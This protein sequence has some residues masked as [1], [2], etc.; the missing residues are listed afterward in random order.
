MSDGKSRDLERRGRSSRAA[1]GPRQDAGQHLAHHPRLAELGEAGADEAG[2]EHDDD[3][4]DEEGRDGGVDGTLLGRDHV[5]GG[6]RHPAAGGRQ[7]LEHEIELTPGGDAGQR[8]GAAVAAGDLVPVSR[9]PGGRRAGR[10]LLLRRRFRRSTRLRSRR[11][12]IV[13]PEALR[14]GGQLIIAGD[15]R[16][17]RPASGDPGAGGSR[18]NSRPERG[19]ADRSGECPAGV[20]DVGPIRWGGRRSSTLPVSREPLKRSLPPAP[21]CGSAKVTNWPD[22]T[23]LNCCPRQLEDPAARRSRRR[24]GPCAAPRTPARRRGNRPPAVTATKRP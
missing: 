5:L 8:L 10:G 12:Q 14:P 22:W 7:R 20:P 15:A 11:A 23:T 18:L 1:S 2:E 16:W 13:P 9:P 6:E 4:R 3:D 21:D 17:R 24:S 19:T